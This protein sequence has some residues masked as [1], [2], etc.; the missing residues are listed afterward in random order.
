M[1]CYWGHKFPI[2]VAVTLGHSAAGCGGRAGEVTS[3]P[4]VSAKAFPDAMAKSFCEGLA[5]CCQSAGH[6]VDLLACEAR[7]VARINA[8]T[9]SS[10]IGYDATTGGQCVAEV[11]SALQGCY[12]MEGVSSCDR[13]YVG[14][15]ALGGICSNSKECAEPS[16]GGVRCIESKCVATAAELRG[17][18]GEGCS[19]SCVSEAN[20]SYCLGGAASTNNTPFGTA[21]CYSEDGLYCNLDTWTCETLVEAGG[22]CRSSFA[23]VDAARCN[24]DVGQ[25]EPR[26]TPGEACA[27]A[28]DCVPDAYCDA[29]H[30]CQ[31]KKTDGAGCILEDECVGYCLKATAADS[32][33]CASGTKQIVPTEALCQNYSAG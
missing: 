2:V 17:T 21:T 30:L 1:S 32:G 9:P 4:P 13:V 20:G 23:C 31:A 28:N 24:V 15:V 7:M 26:P 10:T 22:T 29:D 14:L 8:P 27:S 18:Q 16:A 33:T 5:T 3:S 19:T 6:D 11:R 25:C 12:S